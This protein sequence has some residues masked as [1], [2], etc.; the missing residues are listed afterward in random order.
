MLN[1]KTLSVTLVALASIAGTFIYTMWQG[2]GPARIANRQAQVTKDLVKVT[3]PMTSTVRNF[4]PVA[5]TQLRPRR[6]LPAPVQVS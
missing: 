3:D 5:P 6:E 2:N 4:N 1:R